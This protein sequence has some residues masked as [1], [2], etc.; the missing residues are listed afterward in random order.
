V[1][2]Y[3]AE[4]VLS[5]QLGLYCNL[6]AQFL[7]QFVSHAEIHYHRKV[8]DAA[9][10]QSGCGSVSRTSGQ[11]ATPD[12]AA[13]ASTSMG[14][15]ADVDLEAPFSNQVDDAVGMVSMQPDVARIDNAGEAEPESE[16]SKTSR[17][18]MVP[19]QQ[20]ATKLDNVSIA[21]LRDAA[22]STRAVNAVCSDIETP[23]CVEANASAESNSSTSTSVSSYTCALLEARDRS[24]FSLLIARG[25]VP[26]VLFFGVLLLVCGALQPA[27]TVT[28]SGVVGVILDFGGAGKRSTSLSFF[29]MTEALARQFAPNFLGKSG[30]WTLTIVFLI[31]TLV[32]PVV[33]SLLWGIMWMRPMTSQSLKRLLVISE[34]L[35]A[36]SFFDVF[37]I[38][39]LITAL[40]VER[41][42]FGMISTLGDKLSAEQF[43]MVNNL[44]PLLKDIGFVSSADGSLFQL[45]A[46]LQPGSYVLLAS[47]V[48]LGCV[49][50]LVNSQSTRLLKSRKSGALLN[51]A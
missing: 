3:H 22:A 33:Q 19:V 34:V 31:C 32:M 14:N 42:A 27:L 38:A 9:V 43:A 1:G 26:L 10:A 12:V 46:D 51:A 48:F 17:D 40:Q 47:A 50:I 2:L 37:L 7:S 44:V 21:E 23:S 29:Q 36:W 18:V 15:A 13:S 41:L 39:M 45:S 20:G 6:I 11:D 28:S 25:L 35:S 16:P 30:I 49:G 24:R 8:V 4:V 5:P